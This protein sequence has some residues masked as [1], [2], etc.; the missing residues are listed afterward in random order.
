[1]DST[2]D[3]TPDGT[4][5]PRRTT[6]SL[7]PVDASGG[8]PA[9]LTLGSPELLSIGAF[10]QRVGLTPSALRFYDDC[11]VLPPARVDEAT[12]YRSYGLDQ[13]LRA[14]M[15]R[16]LRDAGLPLADVGVVLDGEE[17]AAR[18]V[19]ERHR[20]TVRDR[21]R[22]AD[23]TIEAV[24]RSLS[25]ADPTVVPVPEEPM[26]EPAT[27]VRLGGAELASAVR[28]VVPAAGR[29]PEHPVLG[30]VLIEIDQYEVRLV[31]TDR[32]RLALRDL[33]PVVS[34]EG[35]ARQLLVAADQLAEVGAWAARR[36]AV[37]V[38]SGPDGTA[39][40]DTD[41]SDSRE[42]ALSDGDFP[43]YHEMLAELPP[44]G[45]RVIVGRRALIDAVG[46]CGDTPGV[47]LG[48]GADELCVSLPDGSRT[49][50]VPAVLVG[51]APPRIGFD[52]G[53]LIPA[54]ESS[55]GPD[56]LLEISAATG[57]VVVRSADQGGFT[58]LVMPIGLA[59]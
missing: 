37:T 17:S 16:S 12:G 45:H 24:L 15:L 41:G 19:L 28:Q 49:T 5:P 38:E 30:C 43:A 53:V 18:A 31:A 52:P 14:K 39:V 25:V 36:T 55:V 33:K 4:T 11:G 22:A 44:H 46:A 27:L 9:G 35:P 57:P 40:R 23:A 3:H 42:L 34:L 59:P 48:P 51:G 1:M 13:A 29:D 20:R 56:V 8:V 6:L 26:A 50:A 2:A 47:A 10:A 21:S 54:L 32:Y 58:M 7:T